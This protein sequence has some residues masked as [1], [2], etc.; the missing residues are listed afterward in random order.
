MQAQKLSGNFLEQFLTDKDKKASENAAVALLKRKQL[1]TENK[2]L[3]DRLKGEI[4]RVFLANSYSEFQIR[5]YGERV[6]I[7]ARITAIAEVF[8]ITVRT[9]KPYDSQFNHGLISYVWPR[10]PK[11][12]KV[13]GNSTLA[14]VILTIHINDADFDKRLEMLFKMAKASLKLR[15]M[16]RS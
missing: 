7:I 9:I 13:S 12:L 3:A 16:I 10:Q 5:E 2:A 8:G 1:E 11:M 4:N 6:T 15:P 14:E